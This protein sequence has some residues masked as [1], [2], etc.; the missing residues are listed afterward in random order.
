MPISPLESA[1]RG[2]G[3]MYGYPYLSAIGSYIG[4]HLAPGPSQTLPEAIQSSENLQSQAQ[5]ANP[6]SYA[7]GQIAAAIPIE[8]SGVIKGTTVLGAKELGGLASS[9]KPIPGMNDMAAIIEQQNAQRATLQNQIRNHLNSSLPAEQQIEPINT[10]AEYGRTQ[11]PFLNVD[12]GHG[13][14]TGEPSISPSSLGPA[15]Q[16]WKDN[17]ANNYKEND[18]TENQ[19]KAWDI[20][21][22]EGSPPISPEY[23]AWVRQRQGEINPNDLGTFDRRGTAANYSAEARHIIDNYQPP[24]QLPSPSS[25]PSYQDWVR[26]KQGTIDPA[27]IN[28]FDRRGSA[29]YYSPETAKFIENQQAIGSRL[30]DLIDNIN[31]K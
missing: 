9:P 27:T 26:Q 14:Y 30:S 16:A 21:K 20:L 31:K 25:T 23:Q 4:Q 17:L 19:A 8:G 29:A 1:A 24:S 12:Q 28:A 15:T 7:A 3:N 10:S 22:A 13:T 11:N 2:A 5:Q 18:M 6:Y